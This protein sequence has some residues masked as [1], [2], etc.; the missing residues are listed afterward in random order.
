MR[1]DHVL[2]LS[3]L[4]KISDLI[5]AADHN[6]ADFIGELEQNAILDPGTDFPVVGMPIFQAKA[7]GQGG[8][9]IKVLH[10]DVKGLIDFL[11]SGG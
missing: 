8:M 4:H 1:I 9:T 10:Q 6:K 5:M 2:S 3:L 11:L 7:R